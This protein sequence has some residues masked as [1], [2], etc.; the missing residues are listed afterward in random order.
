MS[1][2]HAPLVD[3]LVDRLTNEGAA[4]EWRAH[5]ESSWTALVERPLRVLLPPDEVKA[6]V[7]VYLT[8]DRL[9]EIVRAIAGAGLTASVAEMRKDDQPVGRWV[10]D[11]ARQRIDATLA[12]PGLVDESWVR[13]VVAEQAVEDVLSDA[14]YRSLR[15]FSTIIPRLVLKALPTGR[16]AKL[17]GAASLGQKLADEIERI[18]E[19]EIKKFISTGSAKA[20]E[21]AADFAVERVDAPSSVELR[22]HVVAFILS[23][24]PRFHAQSVDEAMLEDLEAVSDAIAR[25]V[26]KDPETEARVFGFIDQLAEAHGDRP[27]SEVLSDLGVSTTPSFEELARAT[28]PLISEAV[29]TPDVRVWLGGLVDELLERAGAA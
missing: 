12:R 19:P 14:L 9:V 29:A 27:T 17:G 5:L 10:P 6:L 4:E 3:W 15:D 23:K 7:S 25:E 21:R 18:I 11:V 13:T 8:E 2:K 24:S 20:L 26:A 16:F 22:R 1:D 28:W